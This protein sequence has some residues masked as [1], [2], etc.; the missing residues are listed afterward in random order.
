MAR[1][2]SKS[3][4]S[5]TIFVFDPGTRYELDENGM[6]KANRKFTVD[7]NPSENAARIQAQ[8]RY[9]KNVLVLGIQ[10]DE[11]KLTVSPETFIANSEICVAGETY[12]RE[13]VTQTFKVTRF[14]GFYTDAD[15]LHQFAYEFAGET[16]ANKLRNMACERT[17]SQN[18]VITSTEVVEERRYMAR[19]K[20]LELAQ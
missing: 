20:Y 6:P 4:A 1:S 3:I 11:T 16:T 17:G 15:G 9:G 12:T 13:Y 8:K 10:V 5:A 7:G 18:T 2:I 14:G 19:S